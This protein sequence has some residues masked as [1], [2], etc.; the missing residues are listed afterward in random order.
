MPSYSQ[1]A[2]QSHSHFRDHSPT[3]SSPLRHTLSTRSN[4]SDAE[5]SLP[6][7]HGTVSSSG[8]YSDSL[9]DPNDPFVT[10]T[11]RNAKRERSESPVKRNAA[12]VKWEQ[13]EQQAE[14]EQ[15]T[16]PRASA[17]ADQMDT[18]P[19]KIRDDDWR[20]SIGPS[21]SR[22]ALKP[23]AN[24]SRTEHRPS[25]VSSHHAPISPRSK[26]NVAFSSRNTELPSDPP[27]KSSPSS[28]N[29]GHSFE[30]S[31]RAP[32]DTTLSQSPS[33]MASKNSLATLSR[34]DSVRVGNQPREDGHFRFHSFDNPVSKL[35]TEDIAKLQKSSTPALRHLSK[36]ASEPGA[37]DLSVHSPDEQVVGLAGRRKLQRSGSVRPN[38][39]HQSAFASQFSSTK[40][41]ETQRKH[42]QAYEYLCHIGEARACSKKHFGMELPWQKLMIS[43][44]A[45]LDTTLSQSPSTMASKNSLATLSRSDSVRVGNQPREDGHFRFHSFDNPVSKLDTEDIAKLQKSSTPALRHLSKMASEPGAEDL[46]VHSPDEQVVGLA[47]RRKLQRSGSVRPNAKHQSAFASQ[48]SSTKW[49]ETQ[50]KHLQ[51]YEY[52]CHIG[53]AR[54]WLEDVLEPVDLPPIVQLEEALRDG[55]TLAEAVIRLTPSLPHDQQRAL[56]SLRIFRNSR[57]QYRHSDNI[58]LF[59]R[60]LAEIELP[61]LFRFE[62]VDL[63][64]KKNVPKVIYCIHALSWLLFRKGL[65]SFRIGNLVGQ[66]Q[67]EDHELEETQKGIDRAGIAMPNFGGMREA[68]QIEPEPAPPEPTPQEMLAEQ[69]EM[70][71]DLQSQI[72]GAMARL[73]LGNVMQNLW[74]A[75]EQIAHFQALARGEFAREVFDFRFAMDRSVRRLQAAG[76]AFLVRSDLRHKECAW[77]DNKQSV[78]KIQ[79]L[80]RGRH[81]RSETRIIKTRLQKQEHGLRELQAA[82]RGTLGRWRAGDVWHETRE[83]GTEVEAFQCAARGALERMRISLIMN[84]LWDFEDGIVTLQAMMRGVKVR[85][86]RQ[87]VN[88]AAQAAFADI[89]R[90]QGAARGLIRR[91]QNQHVYD[92]FRA[93]HSSVIDLQAA[94]RGLLHRV[95]Q[96]KMTQSLLDNEPGITKLQAILRAH[97]SRSSIRMDKAQLLVQDISISKFQ[98]VIRAQQCRHHLSH[99]HHTLMQHTASISQLQ[100]LSRAML[101]RRSIGTRLGQLED[102]EDV[103]VTIQSMARGNLERQ[104]IYE[105]L[106]AMEH[107]EEGIIQLQALARAMLCRSSVGN[108]LMELEDQEDEVLGFQAACRAFLIRSRFEDKRRHYRENM[109]KVIK[110]QSFVRG[111]QQ[112]ESYQSLVNGKNPPL[113]VVRRHLHLL[114]DS[115]LEFEGELEAERLRRQ[116]IES[117]RRNE[118]VEGYVEGLDVKIALL[119]KNKITLDEVVKHQKHFGGSASQLLR[120]GSTLQNGSAF[121]LKAL[122]KSSRKK[123]TGYE[124]LFFMLQTQPGYLA[125]LLFQLGKRG[126]TET[127]VKNVERL[128][129]T[130][131]GYAQKSREEYLLLKV[132]AES[133]QQS[134]VIAQN[135]EEFLRQQNSS[136]HQ[137]LLMTYLRSPTYRAYSKTLLGSTVKGGICGQDNLDLESD[138]LQIY[139]AILNNEELS[140]GQACSRPR[141][142]PR[143]IAIREHDVR[144]TYV[145]HLQDLRDLCDGFF[146]SFEETLQRMPFGIRFVA[147]EQY[148]TLRQRFPHEDPTHLAM[149]AGNWLWKAYLLPSLKEPEMWGVIDRGLSPQHKRNLGQVITVL[150]QVIAGRLFGAENIYLQP[151][152]NWVTESL[153]RWHECLHRLFDMPSAEEHFDAD[154]FKDLYSRT[155]P[156]LYIKLTD[157]F[158]LHSLVADNLPAVVATRDDPLRELLTD[159]GSAKSNESDLSGAVRGGEFTLTLRSRF[160]V[161]EDPNAEARQL[162]TATKRLVLYVIKVQSGSSLMEI[163]TRPIS[164]E[165]AENWI[166]LVRDEAADKDRAARRYAKRPMSGFDPRGSFRGARAQSVYSESPSVISE[167]RRDLFDLE[168]MTYAELKSSALENILTLEQPST[169]AQFRVSRHN[170]YQ[171]ILNA[172]ASDIRQKHRRRLERQSEVDGTRATLAQLDTKAKFLEDQLKSYNDYIE[173]C[174]HTLASKKGSKHK[175]ILPFTKQW[176]HERELERAGRQP[177][178]GSYKYSARQ[179]ADKG[180][181]LSWDNYPHEHWGQLNVVISSDEVG[182]FHLEA[183]SGS[184]M[185]P[186]ASANLL[187]D[188]LLQAQY[189]NRNA[190]NIFEEGG[191][192]RLAV[193]LLLHLVFKKFYRDE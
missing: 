77:Q 15:Q 173:Q 59:F 69:H 130:L 139:H 84:T 110:L 46:S 30:I 58:A 127:E 3:K 193:N 125:R 135:L 190:I 20:T 64:E 33:T 179:L 105:Q 32:L 51:A 163:L 89:S 185:L 167:D 150:G 91:R 11:T 42:L 138:P 1:Y 47:G 145:Q 103:I 175:F 92:H 140:T 191:E 2:A 178:F 141:D 169:P 38:A 34:S 35:D 82:I 108:T 86:A 37:E 152:N 76:K 39:K 132:L 102:E 48:F 24:N 85:S 146:L 137:R 120:T 81:Q 83:A 154:Q 172:L 106:M 128:V 148:R 161:Q 21:E 100:A 67:F 4:N 157:I 79:S 147:A 18:T 44:R 177:K 176:S 187:L 36:M 22:N 162:F 80:W 98:G 43:S 107:E 124:E 189:D 88:S 90:L 153:E 50:R 115:N 28:H 68:M 41:M 70:I 87:K 52:L 54:A 6:A 156:T 96:N 134:V 126:M 53:E 182:V 188:D 14:Q 158:A 16:V 129:M 13:R 192:A 136:F 62:L 117:V 57:L 109:Q 29:R 111:K 95:R 56:G 186:G 10:A 184:M 31:S 118:L 101:H 60:F 144:P 122:N 113:P 9:N 55:V 112:G 71:I 168:G 114:T 99:L 171:E 174:L 170:N 166:Q 97:C 143:E 104:R 73:R 155:K 149:L 116:V 94:T 133:A 66:L 74:D 5:N 123:L 142:L 12:F 121:D 45:S 63:Y 27:K 151:L 49:M 65:V 93:H 183:S 159:L 8:G 40:W 75:E 164:H 131:F 26:E 72:R 181:L 180:V 160:A 78:T 61:E 165:D 7:W 25:Q 17:R 19:R 23:I 119:V